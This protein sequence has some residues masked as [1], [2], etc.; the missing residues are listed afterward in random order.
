M[1]GTIFWKVKRFSAESQTNLK[2]KNFS[3]PNCSTKSSR[4]LER[5]FNNFPHNFSQTFWKIVDRSH[6]ASG[7]VF[8]LKENFHCM[9]CSSSN[10]KCTFSNPAE[11]SFYKVRRNFGQSPK[12]YKRIFLSWKSC[13]QLFPRRS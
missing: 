3:K 10:A 7:K 12:T 11:S 1:T 9:K 6:K 4:H 13:H 8:S 5:T 2:N